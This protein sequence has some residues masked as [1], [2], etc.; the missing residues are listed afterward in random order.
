MSCCN[1][2]CD[3]YNFSTRK[4]I[5]CPYCSFE[6]CSICSRT[7]ILN[8]KV[9]TCMNNS[10]KKEW[11]RK[12]I[13]ESFPKCWV[14]KEWR[15]MK[16]GKEVEI[17]K[18]LLPATQLLLQGSKKKKDKEEI[19]HRKCSVENCRGYLSS[20][21]KC[22]LCS[23]YTCKNCH[24]EKKEG[25]VCDKELV[26]TISFL[27]EDTKPCPKC[28]T[29]IHKIDGCDQMWCTMCHTAFSWRRGTIETRIH[30]PHYYD[31]LRNGGGN[32]PRNDGDYEC[33]RNLENRNLIQSL[34]KIGSIQIENIENI[35]NLKSIPNTNLLYFTCEQNIIY[36]FDVEKKEIIKKLGT[37]ETTIKDYYDKFTGSRIKKF[38]FKST[39]Y[40][41]SIHSILLSSDSKMEL[42]D[43]ET[44]EKIK[45][46]LNDESLSSPTTNRRILLE[47]N[48]IFSVEKN[49]PV[50]ILNDP[51]IRS[52]SYF[53]QLNIYNLDLELEKSIVF[54]EDIESNMAT[55]ISTNV[56][57]NTNFFIKNSSYRE[58]ELWNYK[59]GSKIKN[60]KNTSGGTIILFIPNTNNIVYKDNSNCLVIYN[61]ITD[62]LLYSVY[63]EDRFR[64]INIENE[65]IYIG[66]STNIYIYSMNLTLLKKIS[67]YKL[68]LIDQK[69]ITEQHGYYHIF[70]KNKYEYERKIRYY[71]T[72]LPSMNLFIGR[73]N[74]ILY[75]TKMDE[76]DPIEIIQKTSHLENI[77][78]NK[79]RTQQQ[80]NNEKIR[81]D[82]LFGKLTEEEFGRKINLAYKA[83]EKKQDLKSVLDL[84]VQGVTDIMYRLS[85]ENKN[86]K[87]YLNEVEE[88]T[89]YS[90]SL[91]KEYAK[92][93]GCKEWKINYNTQNVLK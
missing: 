53:N 27:E 4:R 30:N 75:F 78:G 25:H 64:K 19:F 59:T 92:I 60:I 21:W 39:K 26:A 34:S 82:Y 8:E 80:I 44:G 62:T 41:P 7:Y 67:G 12:F 91:F 31:W 65:K 22:G 93:Y 45:S 32:L 3:D 90:N 48:T 68:V 55:S 50:K 76:I 2:C 89:K 29:P 17:E 74:N 24:L 72:F 35:H 23:A 6:A 46:T 54:R 57:H 33:G 36:I 71:K 14:N 20:Q 79:F 18:S 63:N 58:C 5:E 43:I 81:I 70:N 16:M 84:Q 73:R 56:F 42:W 10:C 66:C 15:Q 83:F 9:S 61:Y 37:A 49:I 1:I 13:V 86:E 47:N 11:T 87:N 28:S 40:I 85:A 52:D 38:Y 77:E 88:L 69:I 51:S